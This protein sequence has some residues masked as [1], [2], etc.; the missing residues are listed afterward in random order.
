M[1]KCS[2]IAKFLGDWA[3]LRLAEEWDNVGLH[4]GSMEQDIRKIMICVDVTSKVVDEA[5]AKGVDMIIAHHPLIFKPL[6]RVC[7]D[8]FK[9]RII[10]KLIRNNISVYSAHTNLDFTEG[11]INDYLASLLGLQEV[12][13]LKKYKTDAFYKL[14][15]FV[16]QD[17]EE[18]VRE[19]ICRGGAGWIGNYSD[20]TFSVK[21]TGT[22]KP[23][24]GTNP[25]IGIKEKLERVDEYRI[26]T[27]VPE[28]KLKSVIKAMIGAHPYEEVAY[29][30]YPLELNSKEYG[31]GKAGKLQKPLSLD[32]FIAAVKGKLSIDKVRLI[33]NTDRQIEKVGVFCG[34]FDGDWSGVLK[35]KLDVLV[36]GDIK[37]NIAVDAIEMGLCVIDAGHFG[38]EK[39]IVPLVIERLSKEFPALEI[40]SNSVETDPI[41]FS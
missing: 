36:T 2:E 11:G 35:E 8:D 26:E 5:I 37:H 24:E 19:A 39:I 16:P 7:E 6:K 18:K 28:D 12:K 13:N 10:Y 38:T 14:A 20:C 32:E 3:P 15:V 17:S 4:I 33:G 31:M 29:D 23:L 1:Y 9:G 41:K 40:I 22:F 27:I 21:G 30:V 25:Y 34:G